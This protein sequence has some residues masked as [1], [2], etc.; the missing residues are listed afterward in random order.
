[1]RYGCRSGISAALP[2]KGIGSLRI[3]VLPA[4]LVERVRA[5][6]RKAFGCRRPAEFSQDESSLAAGLP[7]ELVKVSLSIPAQTLGHLVGEDVARIDDRL[8]PIEMRP[9]RRRKAE[10]EKMLDNPTDLA[11]DRIAFAFP[12]FSISSA[13]Q[14]RSRRLSVIAIARNTAAWLCAQA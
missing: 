10:L 4:D 6:F 14:S 9:L 13:R 2:R 1:M 3:P 12:K 7:I 11:A 8:L 5:G